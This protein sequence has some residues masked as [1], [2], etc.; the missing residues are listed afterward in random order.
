MHDLSKLRNNINKVDEEI[1]KLLS[2]RRKLSKEVI[3]AKDESDKPIRDQNRETE[4]LKK[5]IK[6]GK[7]KGIDAHFLTKVFYEIIEDSVRIQMSE[8]QDLTGQQLNGR[9][10]ITVAIQGIEGA[11]SFLAANKFFAH[12]GKDLEF[13]KKKR[14]EEVVTAVEKG[15][16]DYA[17]LPI[18]NTTSGGINEVYDLMLNTSLSIVGE[19]T[20]RVKHCLAALENIS[21]N[22]IKKIYAHYQAAAQCSNFIESLPNVRI[23]YFAD[24]AMSVEKIKEE[25]NPEFAA[26]ASEE[27]ANLFGVHILKTDIANQ[28][29]NYTRFLAAARKAIDV[30]PRIPCK[31]SLVMATAHVPGSLVDALNVFRK[32]NVNITKLE[33]RPILGNPWEEMFYL[34][35]E[36]NIKDETIQH[37]IDDLGVYTRFFKILGSYASQEV[38]KTKLEAFAVTEEAPSSEVKKEVKVEKKIK[39]KKSASYKLASRDYKSEDTIIKVR[40]VEIGGANFV[41]MA[42]PCS[43]ESESQILSCAAEAREHGAQ[44]LRGG[45]FKPRT[46]PYSFQGLGYEGLEMMERAGK[47]YDL[48][49]ITEVLAPDQVI[50]VAKHSD[51]IQIGARN[52]QNFS[53]LKEVGKIHRPV[54]LKRGMMSSLDEL[55]NAAEYILSYGNRQVILCERGIRTFETATR[56][57]L[58]LSAVPVLKELTHLPIIVD[59]SHALGERDKVIPMAKA[60]KIVGAHGIIVEFHPEPEKAL[61]DGPQ[62]LYYHQFEEMMRDL[63]K[64]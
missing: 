42:G 3:K 5:I 12:S 4:L 10:V 60:S 63:K 51:L 50:E 13:V 29:E 8:V 37:L 2:E 28:S 39:S 43:I 38:L 48:P 59:P 20:F 35:F 9:D 23:E 18:E 11:Y 32:F 1:I 22:K 45:C 36:G 30:D 64:L 55:L 47:R 33:S 41:V 25:G 27:A 19:E 54:L 44:I 34:D 49:I 14:F 15:E 7:E 57:T 46:S 58:D 53:L 56:N 17:F 40:D 52:M 24:T 62:A 6:Y 16:A 61:S 31:T 21:I 26:I